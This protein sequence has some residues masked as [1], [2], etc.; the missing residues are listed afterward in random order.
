M[1]IVHREAFLGPW[2]SFPA[3]WELPIHF[4]RTNECQRLVLKTWC[5][6]LEQQPKCSK[7]EIWI[8][9]KSLHFIAPAH[10]QNQASQI[11]TSWLHMLHDYTNKSKSKDF[12]KCR[13]ERG[14]SN[15]NLYF[16]I[17]QKHITVKVGSAGKKR[18]PEELKNMLYP[19]ATVSNGI[20]SHI[21]VP[22]LKSLMSSYGL[23]RISELF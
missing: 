17:F 9:N 19:V 20:S 22:Y 2:H 14:S 15:C 4:T 5:C 11:C 21:V 7:A 1:S 6:V 10:F 16:D 12:G 8:R 3:V 13:W 23:D 18:W